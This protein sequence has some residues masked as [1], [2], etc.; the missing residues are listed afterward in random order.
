[1]TAPWL[2]GQGSTGDPGHA[3]EDDSAAVQVERGLVR[4]RA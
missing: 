2:A 1:M 3:D 4:S